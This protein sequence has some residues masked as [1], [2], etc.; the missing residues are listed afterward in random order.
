MPNQQIATNTPFANL[1]IRISTEVLRK[2]GDFHM[3]SHTQISYVLSGTMKHIV[4]GK[5]YIQQPGSCI[6]V[7][8]YT[9]HTIDTSASE[10][11]PVVI[12]ISFRDSFLTEFGYRYFSYSNKF[13][14]FEEYVLPIYS[15]LTDDKK[16]RA[17]ELMRELRREFEKRKNMSFDRIATLLCD[18][19]RLL[20]IES[21]KTSD[22]VLIEERAN[23]I[24]NAV[25]Y[26]ETHYSEKITIDK[27]CSLAAMSRCIFTKNF[28][29]ITGMTVANF[30]L[31]VRLQHAKTEIL[32]TKKPLNEIAK[33]V[34]LYD[35]ARLSHVFFE[36]YGMTTSE[37]R[38][39]IRP[40]V[41]EE[42]N[43]YLRRWQWISDEKAE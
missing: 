7:P 26:I 18:F 43:A 37:Y 39:A 4:D 19:F 42:H 34:G 31:N 11:T 41:I 21:L 30:I 24:T 28:K 13:A 9:T 10:D 2:V 12:F 38:A 8:A 36:A 29:A 23:A 15:E 25:K 22:F 6:I 35:K 32:F 40:L 33:Q 5:T 1:P 17:D 14:R 16:E 27:L 3:H 20:C